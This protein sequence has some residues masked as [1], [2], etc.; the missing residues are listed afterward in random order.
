MSLLVL[1]S[2]SRISQGIIRQLYNSGK[3]EK[4]VC[5]DLYP[6]YPAIY[7]H[8]NFAHTLSGQKTEL[9]DIQ[10]TG[11]T[12]LSDAIKAASHVVYVTHN[13]YQNTPSKLNL[14]KTT[15]NLVTK[16]KVPN[17]VAV[18]PAEYNH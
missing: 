11:K 12:E 18:T 3:F 6:Q 4:I 1:N 5:A 16:H 7:S 14:I 9:S 10:Y 15:A 17:F 2:A 8:I 13:Y